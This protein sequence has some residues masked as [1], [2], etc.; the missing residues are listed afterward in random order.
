MPA[1]STVE[2]VVEVHGYALRVI[3]QARGRSVV[4]LAGAMDCS[5]SYIAHLERGSKRR[6]S[7]EF[8]NRLL[9]QLGINDFRALLAVAPEWE[10]AA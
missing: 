9:D 3:R 10:K 5:R 8:Y 6:V 2:D 1:Q 7:P 4:D